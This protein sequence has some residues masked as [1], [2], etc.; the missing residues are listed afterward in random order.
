[1]TLSLRLKKLRVRL[2]FQLGLSV[3]LGHCNL[4]LSIWQIKLIKLPAHDQMGNILAQIF[5]WF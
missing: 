3:S 4:V 5:H 1:M 2:I